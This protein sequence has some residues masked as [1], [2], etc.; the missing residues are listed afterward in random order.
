LNRNINVTSFKKQFPLAAS[1]YPLNL[2]M[3]NSFVPKGAKKKKKKT[4]TKP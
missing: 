4:K 3:E 2:G 1:S